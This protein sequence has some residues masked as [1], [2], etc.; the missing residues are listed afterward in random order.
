M[1]MI[2]PARVL[3]IGEILF[4]CLADQ[5]GRSLEQ[6]ASWT[7][8]PGGAPA[9]VACGLVKLGIPTGL[10]GVVGMDEAG[11]RLVQLLRQV[12]VQT[13]G[14][15]QYLAPTR[16]VFVL[17]SDD[18]EREFAG[19]GKPPTNEFAD[20]HLQASQIPESLF[21]DADFLVLGTIALAYPESRQACIHALKMAD[22][23]N[24]K[25][26]VDINWR[27]VFW[28]N[29]LDA[30]RLIPDL[31]KQVDF[32][33]VSTEEAKLFF[34]TT[35]PISIHSQFDSIEGVMI[36]DGQQGCAYSLGEFQG[37]IPAFDVKV[38]DTTGAGDAFVAGFIH[39]LYQY[40]IRG[41]NDPETI[42][43][44]ITY[45][46]AVGALTVTK[47][48]AISAQPTADEVEAFLKSV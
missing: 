31:L 47:P 33:K 16:K 40:G 41:L 2:N 19:F 35:D 14:I 37:K 15:Q 42:K 9:N 6:V 5:T 21:V 7:A 36:T 4:D 3:C 22:R 39:Q 45:A 26:L 30:Q 24:L 28:S 34:N 13:T 43:K 20:T 11:M 44:M 17:R 46:S 38:E 18:G 48:G 1:I 23:Y 12:G 27:P 8:Y 29:P 32:V 10:I 25:I